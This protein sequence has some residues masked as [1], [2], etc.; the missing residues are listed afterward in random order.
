[1]CLGMPAGLEV[2]DALL[3]T[4]EF[5]KRPSEHASPKGLPS[6]CPHRDAS[7]V[8]VLEVSL[9]AGV[10]AAVSG[11]GQFSLPVALGRTSLW[12][13]VSR[14]TTLMKITTRCGSDWSRTSLNSKNSSLGARSRMT[15]QLPQ[16]VT[17]VGAGRRWTGSMEPGIVAVTG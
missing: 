5:I 2:V 4:S 11:G 12:L 8:H 1:M 9:S 6:I 15:N 13:S 7:A 14:S 10:R 17:L 16:S 3:D